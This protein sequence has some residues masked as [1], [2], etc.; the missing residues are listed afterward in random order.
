MV[1]I[2]IVFQSEDFQCTLYNHIM[3]PYLFSTVSDLSF[4][5]DS[6]PVADWATL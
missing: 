6:L 1:E 2:F 4:E 3:A 5:N